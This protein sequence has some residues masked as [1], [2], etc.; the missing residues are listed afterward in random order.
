MIRRRNA[1]GQPPPSRTESRAAA[2]S[3]PPSKSMAKQPTQVC[4]LHGGWC[5]ANR[6]MK[7]KNDNGM[8]MRACRTTVPCCQAPP[9]WFCGLDGAVAAMH[10][11]VLN[12]YGCSSRGILTKAI[13][14]QEAESARAR[15]QPPRPYTGMYPPPPKFVPGHP[16]P[17][18]MW[19]RDRSSEHEQMW[20]NNGTPFQP[21]WCGAA[22]DF[23]G[24]RWYNLYMYKSD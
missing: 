15:N 20:P 7:V 3:K 12:A 11:A 22:T 24:H 21:K 1:P 10:T 18:V 23:F 5:W 9:E 19:A 16:A 13:Y 14:D 4:C 6:T 8:T 17:L 2:C